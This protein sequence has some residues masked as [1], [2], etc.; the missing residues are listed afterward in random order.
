MK[1]D[2]LTAETDL[3]I[4]PFRESL[5]FRIYHPSLANPT[6]AGHDE[7]VAW[8]RSKPLRYSVFQHN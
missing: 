3:R 4:Q 2:N 7:R 1:I 8:S 6:S 5:G